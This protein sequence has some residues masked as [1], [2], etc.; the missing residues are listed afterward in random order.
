MLPR[1]GIMLIFIFAVY[2]LLFAYL[3]FTYVMQAIAL[4][5]IAKR[6]SIAH[7]WLAWVPYGVNWILGAIVSE[8]DLKNGIKRRWD[9][10]LL[11][12]SVIISAF[13]VLSYVAIFIGIIWTA[14]N[15]RGYMSEEDVRLLTM[16]MYI[17]L[18]PTIL[19][20]SVYS[21]LATIC[22]FKIF[23]STVPE[24]ALTYFLIYLL[25]PF[26]APIC[27]FACRNKGYEVMSEDN[28]IVE[29]VSFE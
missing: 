29:Q 1:S 25:V 5:T 27:L 12:F 23:E 6:R 22:V 7:P 3:I 26:A 20:A 17:A 18:I 2:G 8:Y 21:I 10:V 9:K 24:K 11:T 13:E 4:Q 28:L 19:L 14:M 15:M 16:F